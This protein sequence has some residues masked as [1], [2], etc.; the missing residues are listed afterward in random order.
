MADL[1]LVYGAINKE[2]EFSVLEDLLPNWA[3]TV[4]KCSIMKGL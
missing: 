2:A 1:K 4:S 3:Q